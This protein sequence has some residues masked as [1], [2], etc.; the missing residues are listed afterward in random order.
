MMLSPTSKRDTIRNTPLQTRRTIDS[1]FIMITSSWLLLIT[2][3]LQ[4][5]TLLERLNLWIW[6]KRSLSTPTWWRTSRKFQ[7]KR[8]WLCPL[9]ISKEVLIGEEELL[10]EWRTREAVDHAGL[11]R[12]SELWKDTVLFTEEAWLSSLN[13]SWLIALDLMEPNAMDAMEDGQTKP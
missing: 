6:L 5:L 12:L 13:S 10:P 8:R 3:I 9:K 2:M 7:D 4:R 11:S 1:R